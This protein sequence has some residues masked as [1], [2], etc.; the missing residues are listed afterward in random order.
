MSFQIMK[1][2]TRGK[3]SASLNEI[4]YDEKEQIVQVR[5]SAKAEKPSI[6]LTIK[7]FRWTAK[8]LEFIEMCLD[9]HT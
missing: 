5:K 7:E 6:A 1:S 3:R 2:K 9:P 4:E 8:Q